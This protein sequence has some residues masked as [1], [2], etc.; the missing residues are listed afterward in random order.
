MRRPAI[1][2]PIAQ[3]ARNT[4]ASVDPLSRIVEG[5]RELFASD[6]FGDGLHLPF[7][8]AVV[9]LVVLTFRYW[10]ASYGVY[11]AVVVFAALTSDNLNS[12]ERYALDAFPIVLTLASLTAPERAERVT[13]AVCGGGLL[14]L[15]AVACVGVYVP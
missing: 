8:L 1:N 11:A 2:G 10:P 15:T 5:F 12:F 7:V 14:A 13:L 4:P 9:A 6:T 3:P